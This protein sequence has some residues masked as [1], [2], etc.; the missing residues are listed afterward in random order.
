[1]LT[2]LN[3]NDNRIGIEGAKALA[4]AL[5]VN[6]VLKNINLRYNSLGDEG[7]I[8]DAVSGREGFKLEM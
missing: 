4:A 2:A 8:R 6:R 1:V 3:L 5:R 7:M